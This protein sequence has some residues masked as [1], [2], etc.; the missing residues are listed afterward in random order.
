M[1]EL[2]NENL[3][4]AINNLRKSKDKGWKEKN[5]CYARFVGALF[6]AR[7][8]FPMK[9]EAPI[10]QKNYIA[11]IDKDGETKIY[12]VCFTSIDE[13]EKYKAD[14]KE[15]IPAK[16]YSFINMLMEIEHSTERLDGIIIDPN[17]ICEIIE[18]S[19][20][21]GI[22]SYYQNVVDKIKQEKEDK[23]NSWFG[24]ISKIY[25]EEGITRELLGKIV[26]PIGL[27]LKN[28]G[29]VVLK[30]QLEDL[31]VILIVADLLDKGSINLDI[32]SEQKKYPIG[33][34]K[35]LNDYNDNLNA[36]SLIKSKLGIIRYINSDDNLLETLV[37]NISMALLQYDIN[38]PEEHNI[39]ENNEEN[40]I[41]SFIKLLSNTL[42]AFPTQIVDGNNCIVEFS[43]EEYENK[44]VLAFTSESEKEKW[45][46]YDKYDIEVMTVKEYASILS[47]IGNYYIIINH[48]GN[49]LVVE[50]RFMKELLNQ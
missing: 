14:I 1:E 39:I 40:D 43:G 42:I 34:K 32:I 38:E 24:E 31:F 9:R 5:Y 23:I 2:K 19:E 28:T 6:N 12:D 45:R 17:G 35:L 13:Y 25:K 44:F 29:D 11:E 26:K 3:I 4:G 41:K 22:F 46:D 49:K 48:F 20:L 18:L 16:E 21:K 47:N 36:I 27:L 33:I 10:K 7:V 30:S 8:Y 15:I 37:K 50:D